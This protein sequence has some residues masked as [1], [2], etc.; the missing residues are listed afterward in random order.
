MIKKSFIF[1]VIIFSSCLNISKENDIYSYISKGSVLN[2]ELLKKS[3]SIL[4]YSEGYIVIFDLSTLNKKDSYD[5]HL[6]FFNKEGVMLSASYFCSENIYDFEDGKILAYLNQHRCQRKRAFRNDVPNNIEIVYKN[7][8]NNKNPSIIYKKNKK[9]GFLKYNFES[10]EVTIISKKE[11][12][13]NRVFK[14]PLYKITYNYDS[15]EIIINDV[16]NDLNKSQILFNIE[17]V[18]LFDDFFIDLIG[19]YNGV[20]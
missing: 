17:E 3:T 2:L 12:N 20:K 5:P 16:I 10:N 19:N 8:K 14:F 18:K 4:I 13:K 6:L 7:Y 1:F 11:Q 9:I 15:L